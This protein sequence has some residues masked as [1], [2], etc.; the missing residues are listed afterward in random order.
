MIHESFHQTLRQQILV[1][2]QLSRVVG[3]RKIDGPFG[4]RVLDETKRHDLLAVD[5]PRANSRDDVVFA[6]YLRL[7]ELDVRR[8]GIRLLE[9][10]LQRRP[11][12]LRPRSPAEN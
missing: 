7:V 2:A 4:K 9:S 12:W 1:E 11:V 8:N 6:K 5:E 10:H 3:E